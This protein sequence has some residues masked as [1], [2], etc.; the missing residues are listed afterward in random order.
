MTLHILN[1]CE[2]DTSFYQSVVVTPSLTDDLKVV[3]CKLS[4]Y[5]FGLGCL[6][7]TGFNCGV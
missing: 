2:R 1:I 7:R 4:I 5:V 3:S 6:H